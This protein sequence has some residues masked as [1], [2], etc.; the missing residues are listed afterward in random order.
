MTQEAVRRKTEG[1]APAKQAARDEM[2]TITVPR[3]E[4]IRHFGERR[5]DRFLAEKGLG[6][7]GSI[8]LTVEN[9]DVARRLIA[10]EKVGA[11]SAKALATFR[12]F[13]R[14]RQQ[15]RRLFMKWLDEIGREVNANGGKLTV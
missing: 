15:T 13:F 4:L 11:R 6:A 14:R 10:G 3:S 1:T 7:R 8:T 9:L 5:T 2:V 12:A